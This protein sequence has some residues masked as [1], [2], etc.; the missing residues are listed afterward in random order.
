MTAHGPAGA[1]FRDVFPAPPDVDPY[2]VENDRL[3]CSSRGVARSSAAIAADEARVPP[4][5]DWDAGP[6]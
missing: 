6:F 1:E 5:D 3:T 4:A 2:A